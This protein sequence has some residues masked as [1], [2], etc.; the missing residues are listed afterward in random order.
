M[1]V[2]VLKAPLSETQISLLFKHLF[3]LKRAKYLLILDNYSENC[4]CH[5]I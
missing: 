4:L 1:N 2:G 3:I 5:K